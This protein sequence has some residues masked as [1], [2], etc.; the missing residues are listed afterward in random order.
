MAYTG[1]NYNPI[2]FIY[3]RLKVCFIH[4]VL[5]LFLREYNFSNYVTLPT[6]LLFI[7]PQEGKG[8]PFRMHPDDALRDEKLL[9]WLRTPVP[10]LAHY[11]YNNLRV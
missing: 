6:M 8:G 1:S 9:M 4:L 3:V 2:T 5:K 11:N 7:H 10:G